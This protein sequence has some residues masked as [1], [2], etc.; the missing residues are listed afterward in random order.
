MSLS[1]KVVAATLK[2]MT[3]AW[4]ITDPTLENLETKLPLTFNEQ[5]KLEKELYLTTGQFIKSLNGVTNFE[6]DAIKKHSFSF[7]KDDKYCKLIV[8]S[9]AMEEEN[10]HRISLTIPNLTETFLGGIED[11]SHQKFIDIIKKSF[12]PDFDPVKDLEMK[13]DIEF[14]RMPTK[15]VKEERLLPLYKW[16]GGKRDE[17]IY[18]QDWFPEKKDIKRYVEPF[19]GAGADF[20]RFEHTSNIISDVHKESINFLQQLEDG[21]GQDIYDKFEKCHF[22]EDEYYLVRDRVDKKNVFSEEIRTQLTIQDD[23]TDAFRFLYLRKTC[24]RGMSRYSN[25]GGVLK[26]NI[27]WGRYNLA[28]NKE[29]DNEKMMKPVHSEDKARKILEGCQFL[30]GDTGKRYRALLKNTEILNESF[31][32]VFRKCG[33]GDF[34]YLDPPYDSVFT[35]YGYCSFGREEHERLFYEFEH[36]KA[37]CLLVIGCTPFVYNLYKNYIKGYYDKKYRFKLYNGRILTS[38]M[39]KRHLIITNLGVKS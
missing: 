34:I 7:K 19:F 35:D 1:E 39:N 10:S 38:D 37:K 5:E 32:T 8:Q 15:K 17:F 33:E 12:E 22:T 31:E 28:N 18:Y 25:T 26:F 16:S 30:I 9:D 20:F 3:T 14:I 13:E 21:K 2:W 11:R 6:M 23:V 27:P 4:K 36:T 24:F 29:K